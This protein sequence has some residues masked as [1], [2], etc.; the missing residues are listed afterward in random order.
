LPSTC[1]CLLRSLLRRLSRLG[2]LCDVHA[3]VHAMAQ[4]LSLSWGAWTLESDL[5]AASPVA[6][7]R[8]NAHAQERARARE[9]ESESESERERGKSRARQPLRTRSVSASALHMANEEQAMRAG[10]YVSD[11]WLW[12]SNFC[13]ISNFCQAIPAASREQGIP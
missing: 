11:L 8:Q 6:T 5:L 2:V 1:S 3:F 4:G 9:S 12:I 10:A 13:R 7:R